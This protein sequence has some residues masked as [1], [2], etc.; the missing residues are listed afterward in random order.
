MLFGRSLW[1][2]EPVFAAEECI[3][4]ANE[5]FKCSWYQASSFLGNRFLQVTT[6]VAA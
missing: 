5:T 4:T 2:C 3:M 6:L 1:I